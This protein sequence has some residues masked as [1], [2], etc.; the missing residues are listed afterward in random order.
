MPTPKKF[1]IRKF[2]YGVAITLR[3]IWRLHNKYG[4]RIRYQKMAD[5]LA[6]S[7]STL[8]RRLRAL[9]EDGFIEVNEK[10][11]NNQVVIRP[12]ELSREWMEKGCC[13]KLFISLYGLRQNDTTKTPQNDTTS[14]LSK[15]SSLHLSVDDRGAPPPKNVHKEHQKKR[16]EPSFEQIA[17]NMLSEGVDEYLVQ[18]VCEVVR[19]SK[20]PIASPERYMRKVLERLKEQ[21]E[22]KFKQIK[23]NYSQFIPKWTDDANKILYSVSDRFVWKW[24]DNKVK[25]THRGHGEYKCFTITNPNSLHQIRTWT[26]AY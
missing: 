19:A 5:E 7:L 3:K 12:T 24:W 26:G 10:F 4:C 25:V 1:P 18:K 17:Q 6:T 16:K 20:T 22:L 9:K 11:G 8:Y 13:P 15:T 2:A 21:S 14:I 23:E